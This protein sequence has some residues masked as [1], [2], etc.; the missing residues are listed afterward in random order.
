[1]SVFRAKTGFEDKSLLRTYSSKNWPN[2]DCVFQ[3]DNKNMSL[4]ICSKKMSF[5]NFDA[6]NIII[7]S[8]LMKGGLVVY[9]FTHFSVNDMKMY[10][11]DSGY[12]EK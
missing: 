3:A 11:F 4:L 2:C 1:M 12:I 7:W 8:V 10:Y 9:I 6:Y 5:F